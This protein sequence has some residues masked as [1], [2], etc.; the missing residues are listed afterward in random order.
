[1]SKGS[2][3]IKSAK[4][5]VKD[6]S[7]EKKQTIK[8]KEMDSE[9]LFSMSHAPALS[10]S[11]HWF[12]MLPVLFFTAGVILIVRMASY[13]RPM[14]QFFWSGGSNDLTDFFSYYKMYAILICA[15]FAL[16]LLAYRIFIQSFYIKRSYAYIPMI[17]YTI[18]VLLSYFF[19]DYKLFALWGWND[20]FEGT[21]TLLGYMVMLFYVINTVNSERNVKL[22]IYVLAATSTLLGLLGLSQ[23][24]D[25][26]FFRTDIGKKLITPDWFWNQLENLDFTFQDKQIYQTVYNINYVSFYLTLLIPLFGLLFIRSI[27]KGKEE[28][29]LKK[30]LWGGLFFLLIYNLIGSASSGGI[31]G[32][33]VAVL[34]AL[35]VLN[36][37]ILSWRKPVLILIVLTIIVSGVTY[38]RWAPELTDSISLTTGGTINQQTGTEQAEQTKP[39]IDYFNTEGYVIH[40]SINGEALSITTFP[41]DSAS[42]VLLDKD[43]NQIKAVPANEP[44][45]FILDDPR[46]NMCTV[47]PAKDEDNNP[48]VV[49]TIADSSWPFIITDEGVL[50]ANQ[51]GN[52]VDLDIIPSIGFKDYPDFGSGRGF[53]WSRSLPLIKDTMLIGHGADTFCIYFPHHDY[54]GKYNWH[55]NM[56]LIIDKPHNMYIGMAFGTGLL[57]LIALLGM[58]IIYIIQSIRIYWNSK[59]ESF[60]EFAGA[61]IFLGICGF[62]VAGVVNDSSVSVMPMFYGLLGT[63]IAINQMLRKTP[64]KA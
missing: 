11:S 22:L 14:S 34:M 1:M 47:S 39:V 13:E 12:Q 36:R 44:N 51:L 15:V 40:T 64:N 33:A 2:R 58:W 32:M 29:L 35:L 48:Y 30:L 54:A 42:I 56:N 3:N 16:V 18:F 23:A 49:L 52:L 8:S 7:V 38:Q 37:Q 59:F 55:N 9:Y 46:F 21:L 20:R 6:R 63:G 61:G 4:N 17:V 10:E 31:L 27:N 28:T 5:M 62:L 60:Q 19:S 50:F 24:L 26:D 53:I 43:Q 57:S 25:H 41:D 45:T